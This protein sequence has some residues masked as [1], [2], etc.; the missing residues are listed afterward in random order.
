M[1]KDEK[2]TPTSA[3]ATCPVELSAQ[4]DDLAYRT[5]FLDAADRLVEDVVQAEAALQTGDVLKVIQ[6]TQTPSGRRPLPTP[7]LWYPICFLYRHGL[8]LELKE[9][10]RDVQH[11]IRLKERARELDKKLTQRAEQL[12]KES[13]G[14][15]RS[16]DLLKLLDRGVVPWLQLLKYDGLPLPPI[17][18]DVIAKLHQ[19]DPTGEAFRYGRL[20]DGNPTLGQGWVVDFVQLRDGVREAQRHLNSAANSAC[21]TGD[22][23]EEFLSDQ[24]REF[25]DMDRE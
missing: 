25:S 9:L 13:A 3:T 15:L 16:H 7:P 23:V 21:I 24:L 12:R 5:G 8:E 2:P 1:P 14:L 17:V 22:E 19:V 18:R 4:N 10:I 6:A 20:K 11:A